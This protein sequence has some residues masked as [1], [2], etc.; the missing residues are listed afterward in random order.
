[1]KVYVAGP[2][3][4]LP[5]YNFPLF[6]EVCALLRSDYPEW[7]VISPHEMDEKDTVEGWSWQDFMRRDMKVIAD[8]H[9]IA[10]LPG[11]A[12]SKGA[13]LEHHVARELG[14]QRWQIVR[15][16][17]GELYATLVD[18]GNPVAQEVPSP[19]IAISDL[20]KDWPGGV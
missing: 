4:G 14:L 7:E 12:T 6:R 18:T 20:D 9:A 5:E 3:S 8:C 11:W 16:G 19:N 13:R 1:M 15:G 2:M 17:D 10:L